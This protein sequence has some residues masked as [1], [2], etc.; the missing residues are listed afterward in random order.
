MYVSFAPVE[1]PQIA[2]AVVIYDG[3]NGYLGAPVARAIL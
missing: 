2:V 1:D 3:I